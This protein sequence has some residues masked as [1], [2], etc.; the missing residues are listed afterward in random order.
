M[1]VTRYVIFASQYDTEEDARADYDAVRRLYDELN[2]VDTYDA[3]VITKKPDG[4]VDIVKVDEQPTRRGAA[5]GLVTGLALGAVAALFPAIGLAAGLAAGG[6]VGTGVGAIAGHVKGGMSRSDLKDLGE[7]LDAGSSGLVVVT[8][9]DL[10][11]RVEQAMTRARRRARG[12][13]SA[14]AEKFGLVYK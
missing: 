14:D 4:S 6:A 9:T 10:E 7:L 8:A 12:E 11:K 5:A 3:A 1:A 2:I 13:L